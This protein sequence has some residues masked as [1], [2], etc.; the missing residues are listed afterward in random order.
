MIVHYHASLPC[1]RGGGGGRWMGVG[2]EKD[3]RMY[4]VQVNISQVFVD[5]VERK[6][7]MQE[8]LSAGEDNRGQKTTRNI[9]E[10]HKRKKE[11]I[12]KHDLIEGHAS[13][14][15]FESG[16]KTNTMENARKAFG[17]GSQ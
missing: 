7:K 6:W 1:I 11:K 13:V 16:K 2:V 12:S 9:Q 4:I 14:K 10:E 17:R 3:R 15:P 8:R 5:G